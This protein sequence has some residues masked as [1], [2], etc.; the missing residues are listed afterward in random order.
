ME[1]EDRV[2]GP[3]E[4][5]LIETL[6]RLLGGDAPGVR[7]GPGDDAA[8]VEVGDRLAILTVDML[9]EG[10]DFELDTAAARD[11]GYKAVQVN[12]SDVAAMGGS[13]RYGLVALGLPRTIE[14]AWV[15]ELYGGMREAAGEHAVAVV[16]GDISRAD[17]VVL[18]VTMTGEAPAGGAVLRSGAKPGDRVVVTGSLGAAAGGLRLL[19]AGPEA[20]AAARADGWGRDLLEAQFRPVAR[21]GEG[22]SLARSG[23]TA[24]IDV[25]DGLSVD[26]WRLCRASG[27]AAAVTL[28]RVPLAPALEPLAR[29]IE[30]DPLALALGGGEDLELIATLP[31]DAVR[32]AAA[33]LA[34]RFATALTDIGEIRAGSG[35][36]AVSEDGAER[37]MEPEGWDHLA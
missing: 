7:L 25:S 21:V 2:T 19:R 6:R 14:Q 22:Q 32:S 28:G 9:V 23:A 36:V 29:V 12:A 20:V 13:P 17:R 16:G 5:E 37:P 35:L 27:V 24:M 11:I 31:A 33:S 10:V 34:E 8:L 18:A 4:D 30:V 1:R 26:L 3:A 15:V